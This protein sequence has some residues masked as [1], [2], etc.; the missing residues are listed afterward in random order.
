MCLRF[1]FLL[2]TLVAA[3]LRLFWREEA[4]PDV[5]HVDTVFLK[6]LYF[7]FV[8]EF[9]TR[10]VHI[11]GVTAHPTG[12]WTVQQARNLLMD[13]AERTAQFEFLIATATASSRRRSTMRSPAMACGSSRLRSGYRGRTPSRNGMREHYGANALTTSSS[14]VNDTS[15]GL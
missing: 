2:I 7:F 14:A 6:R 15:G 10:R 4:W 12:A 8:M 5:L 1:V 9:Q 13:L 3:W 11:L